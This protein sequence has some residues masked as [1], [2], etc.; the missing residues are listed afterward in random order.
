MHIEK[1]LPE[2]LLPCSTN[3]RFDAQPYYIVAPPFRQQ[4]AG[5]R[6]LHELCSLLNQ[7]GYEA[8]IDAPVVSGHLWTPRLTEVTKIGHHL[9]GKTPI[10]VYPEVV[11]KTPLNLGVAV[12]Y[13]LNYPSLL[14]GDKSYSDDELIYTYHD[15]YYP[16]AKRLYLPLINLAAI[17]AGE[18]VP[19]Q[20]RTEIAYYH[21]RYTK[22]GGVL[23]DFGPDALEISSTQ[24]DTNEKTLALLKRAKLLYCYESSGI[25]LEAT[26]CGCAVVMLPNPITLKQL[27]E[28]LHELGMDGVAW[29]DA[30][31]DVAQALRTVAGRRARHE[32]DLAQWQDE[33]QVFIADTQAAALACPPER[34]WP[35][36]TVDQLPMADLSVQALAE[37]AERRK[38]TR[39]NEQYQRW[40]ARC[41]LREIDADIYAE[42][43]S[44]GQ[45]PAVGVLIDHRHAHINWLADTLDSLAAGLVQPASVHILSEQ[46]APPELADE[47]HIHW[48]Q[49]TEDDPS[50]Q[51]QTVNDA[52]W[53]LI[54]QSGT[55]I[56]PQGIVEWALATRD[57]PQADLLYADDDRMDADGKRAYPFFKPDATVE[58]LRCTND[59]GNAVLLRRSAWA[60]A[61]YPVAGPALY[62][63]ALQQLGTHGRAALGHIDTV[64]SH[65]QGQFDQALE[66][67]EY[68]AASQLLL[69]DGLCSRVQP[70]ER[71]G[72]W[73]PAYA[74]RAEADVSL[75]VPTGLQP[76]Y[77]RSLIESLTLFP[78]PQ[79]R[80]VVLVLAPGQVAE[81][82]YA[83]SDVMPSI[84]VHFVELQQDEYKHGPALNAGIACASSAYILV[85]DD[86]TEMLHSNWLEP[87]LGLAGQADVGCVSPRLMAHRGP[88]ARVVGGPLVLGINGSAAPYNGDEGRL[89][90]AGLYS[91]LQLAQDVG[92]VAGH[93]FLFARAHWQAVGGFNEKEFALWNPVLDFCLRLGQTGL[94]HVWTPASSVLHQGGKSVAVLTRDGRTRFRLAD[95]ELEEKDAL[96]RTWAARLARDGC[97]NRH[98]SLVTPFDVESIVVVDWQPKRHERPRLMAVPLTSGAGQYRVLEPLNALQD[99]SLAQTCVVLPERR[100]VSR[101]L[102]PLELVRAAPDRLILQHAVDD[103][104]LGLVEKYRL[105]LPG[106]QIIQMV[107]DLL[108]DVPAKHPNRLFQSREG[109]QRMIQALKLSDKLVVTT[110]PLIAHYQKYV[111][112]VRLV[113]NAL[114]KQWRDL[115]KPPAPRERLRV[116]WVGAAQ[117]K[118]DL[119]LVTEVV[120]QLAGEVDWVFMGMATDEIKPLLKEFHGFVSISDYPKTMAGLDLDIAIAPLETN[121]FNACKSNLRLLEYGAMGWPVV[122]SDVFPYRTDNPPVI[123]CSDDVNEWVNALRSLAADPDRRASLGQQL[124]DWVGAHYLLSGRVQ[125]WKE[126]L[127]DA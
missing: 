79:L 45:L 29:G 106:I 84:P 102:Q 38:Y 7:L 44:A 54:I 107:D 91:R 9:A 37:R 103:A 116:G 10:V 97:Y 64:L 123:R 114:D 115:R 35:L 40:V 111:P 36:A 52:D 17:D 90:E 60:L 53:L 122:C 85:C 24:P 109:H 82:R 49:C 77:L 65:G 61:H 71:W 87:L 100:N 21:N 101:A 112:D 50:A 57:W 119:D 11:S 30:P 92:S 42:T 93:C 48:L 81:V 66:N 31:D 34:A 75:V 55:R 74:A 62:A 72:T 56:A 2:A 83:L 70:L 99:A 47:T 13:V 125:Q 14:G 69:A 5:I 25:V 63:F 16:G 4:S 19:T 104:Q 6:L 32:A 28:A 95:R 118:G 124:H 12:R 39:V 121:I 113:P 15:C 86:D 26:L 78:Q 41:T 1:R 58:L 73:L 3:Y 18:R 51:V 46:P 120:R 8:Y 108:G 117:H 88:D 20:E 94:R 127:L 22:S 126:C 67:Q 43:L 76:G 68:L 110:E 59:L 33:L 80:E 98:L 23:R 105:A 89:E 96:L 27:P